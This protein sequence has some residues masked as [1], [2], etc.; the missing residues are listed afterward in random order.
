MLML[1]II[2]GSFCAGMEKHHINPRSAIFSN[3]P[4]A[5][6]GK[7]SWA[8]LCVLSPSDVG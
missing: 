6:R 2:I 5:L 3:A 4:F 8:Y 1:S 7:I